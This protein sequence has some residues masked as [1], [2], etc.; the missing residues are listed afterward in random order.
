MHTTENA[1]SRGIARAA[2]IAVIA[3]PV[4]ADLAGGRTTEVSL[5]AIPEQ[6]VHS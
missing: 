2:P 5:L 6:H 3:T 1:T 4:A